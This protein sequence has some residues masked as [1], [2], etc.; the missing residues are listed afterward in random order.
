MRSRPKAL[1]EG[2]R[3]AGIGQWRGCLPQEDVSPPRDARPRSIHNRGRGYCSALRR[4]A[5]VGFIQR[6]LGG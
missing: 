6:F 5:R 2:P 4:R 3:E 1:P